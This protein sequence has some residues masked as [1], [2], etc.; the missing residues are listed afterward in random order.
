MESRKEIEMEK[1]QIDLLAEFIMAEV[2]GEPSKSEGAGECAI[3]IIRQLTAERDAARADE[4]DTLATKD[5]YH[6]VLSAANTQ[7]GTLTRERDS[8]RNELLQAVNKNCA[9]DKIIKG[10]LQEIAKRAI[11][12]ARQK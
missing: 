6:M 12:A 5:A 4:A 3:R 10:L 7:I 1:S 11:A 8:A 9:L 2:P